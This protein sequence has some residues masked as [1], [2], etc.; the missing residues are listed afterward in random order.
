ML[1]VSLPQPVC[2]NEAAILSW[3]GSTK[4]NHFADSPNFVLPENSLDA[5]R[6]VLELMLL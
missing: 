1:Q 2:L 4:G 3:S 5:F 6:L